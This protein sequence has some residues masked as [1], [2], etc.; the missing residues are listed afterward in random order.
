M[1]Y[2]QAVSTIIGCP[3]R[4]TT[5]EQARQLPHVSDKK[6]GKI[7]S[8]I[9]EF[10]KHGEIQEASEFLDSLTCRT[11]LMDVWSR[12]VSEGREAEVYQRLSENPRDWY[13]FS[14]TLDPALISL[15]VT[16]RL[17]GYTKTGRGLW[18]TS[19]RRAT[20]KSHSST[21]TTFNRSEYRLNIRLSTY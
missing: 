16:K 9:E 8:K 10:L 1:S 5:V 7:A 15:Q 17:R 3:H 12:R 19:D 13:A 14:P 18:T 2:A 4:I 11:A 21:L 20:G 6:D